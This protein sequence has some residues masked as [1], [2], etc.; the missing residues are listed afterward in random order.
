MNVNEL[1]TMAKSFLKSEYQLELEIPIKIN[2]RIKRKAGYFKRRVNPMTGEQIPLEISISKNLIE[3]YTKDE[4]IGILKH[5]LIHY[6]L[7]KKELPFEDGHPHF[8]AEL[9]KKGALRTNEL[10]FKGNAYV[11]GCESCDKE[12]KRIKRVNINKYQ[13]RCGGK[14][15]EKGL[16]KVK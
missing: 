3:N 13:C 8:E 15:I 6:A 10:T 4:V 9:Q 1:N 16:T 11:Y 14:L 12:F 2:G 5:E 7:F